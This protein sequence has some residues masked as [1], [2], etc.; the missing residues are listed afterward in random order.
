VTVYGAQRIDLWACGE[1]T[2]SRDTV[3]AFIRLVCRDQLVLLL[4]LTYYIRSSCHLS[5]YSL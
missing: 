2:L 3:Q 1:T 5:F 4:L